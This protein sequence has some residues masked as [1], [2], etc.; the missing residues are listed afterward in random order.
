MRWR[1]RRLRPA[2]VDL[3]LG[4]DGSAALDAH[5]ATCDACR[6]DLAGMRATARGLESPPVPEPG[7]DF[8]RAQRASILRRVRA[9]A[10]ATPPRR[11]PTWQL[12]GA[13]VTLLV[14]LLA[15][16]PIV[17][18]PALPR[19]VE[20]LD[21]ETLHGLHDLLTAIAPPSAIGD[22]DGDLLTIHDLGEEEL[23]HLAA[24][25]GDPS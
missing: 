11:W 3:A 5:V 23:D 18:S 10:P 12:A 19:A 20:H 22:A 15:G 21:D 2:L 16:V 6:H 14:A 1:C 7:P 8:W 24:V 9:T 25:L 4:G 17:R 13:V